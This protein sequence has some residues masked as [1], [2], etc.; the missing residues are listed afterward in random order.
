[1]GFDF[2][3][4][5][6]FSMC[7]STGKP[8]VWKHTPEGVEKDYQLPT[9]VVPEEHRR[10]LQLRGRFLHIYTDEFNENDIFS[11]D[12]DALLEKFPGWDFIKN[13]T[14]YSEY[15]ENCDWTEKDHYEFKAALEWCLSQPHW[16]MANWNY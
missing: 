15:A 5:L 16:Y 12:I 10:F 13:D 8:Y 3:I 2:Y 6:C 1:M 4:H 9:V 14:R 7:P 11:A